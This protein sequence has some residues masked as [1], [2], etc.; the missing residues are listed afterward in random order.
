[1]VGG[2]AQDKTERVA[3]GGREREATAGHMI[4]V[5]GA[6]LAD[7]HAN[8]SATQRLLHRPQ[9]VASARRRDRDQTFGRDAGIVQ[10]GSVGHAILGEREILGDPDCISSF[11]ISSF[12]ISSWRETVWCVTVRRG[13]VVAHRQRQGETGGSGD[14]G[15]ARGRDLMQRA[16]EKAA[17]ENIVDQRDTQR[18]QG[19]AFAGEA[20]CGLDRA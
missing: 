8:C 19:A 6:Q 16:A 3:G 13:H 2:G 1:M 5:A 14:L 10:T 20:G 12:C 9:H 11:C 17:A 7:H 4:D 18:E 15:F